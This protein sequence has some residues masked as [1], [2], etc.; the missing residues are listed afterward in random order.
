MIHCNKAWPRLEKLGPSPAAGG[1]A[2][3]NGAAALKSFLAVP[4]K[5]TI[6][7]RNP[8]SG[9]CPGEMKTYAHENW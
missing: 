2:G 8:S 9:I 7:P 5:V 4:L 1:G 6:R 3:L